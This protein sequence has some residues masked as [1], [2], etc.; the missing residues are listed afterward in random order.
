M[1]AANLVH[2]FSANGGLFQRTMKSINGWPT[3]KL[4]IHRTRWWTRP[5]FFITTQMSFKL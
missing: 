3:Y 4:F 5:I 1:F 2:I